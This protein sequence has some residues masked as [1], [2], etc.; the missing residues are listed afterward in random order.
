MGKSQFVLVVLCFLTLN[1]ETGLALRC[2]GCVDPDLDNNTGLPKDGAPKCSDE[3]YGK[4]FDCSGVCQKF[5]KP[6]GKSEYF[7]KKVY[8]HVLN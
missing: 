3:G 5:V 2:Y 6:N 7:F 8:I 4:E 1:I